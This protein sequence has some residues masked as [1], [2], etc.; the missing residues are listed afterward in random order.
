[1]FPDPWSTR[2]FYQ[3]VHNLLGTSTSSNL[4]PRSCCLLL[5]HIYIA[6]QQALDIR[7]VLRLIWRYCTTFV[8]HLH[9]E[10]ERRRDLRREFGKSRNYRNKTIFH[11]SLTSLLLQ[12][13]WS[14][15][16]W[17]A[18]LSESHLNSSQ[19]NRFHLANSLGERNARWMTKTRP[20]LLIYFRSFTS[21]F[22][23]S[24][25]PS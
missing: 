1:M 8:H 21:I 6:T 3:S 17:Q 11:F 13:E 24:A 18:T 5:T 16:C 10:R 14:S 22:L 25:H 19:E 2:P 12:D 23:H 4:S 15:S 20:L 7:P 9:L